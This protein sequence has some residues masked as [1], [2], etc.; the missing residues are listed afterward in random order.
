MQIVLKVIFDN[1]LGEALPERSYADDCRVYTPDNSESKFYNIVN[2]ID[3]FVAAHFFGWTMKMWIFR[4]NVMAWTAS[5]LFEVYEWTMEVWLDNFA[6]CWWDHFILDMF[7]CNLIG[8]LIGVYTINKFKMKKYHWFLEPNEK[9]EKMTSW[10]KFKYYFTSREEYIK[11]GKWHWLA[12]TWTFNSVLWYFS[13]NSLLELSYFFNKTNL[14]IPPPHW[15][16][17]VRIWTIALFCIL[18]TAEYYEYITKRK[19]NAMGANAFLIHVIIILEAVLWLK[20]LDCNFLPLSDFLNKR[21][22][23]DFF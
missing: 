20:H 14:E 22:F 11:K 6:E 17:A 1:N 7:G 13:I 10:Q 16:M 19:A 5:I 21:V 18:A 8:M 2:S 12:D 23:I 15:L 4:N 3:E 9:M